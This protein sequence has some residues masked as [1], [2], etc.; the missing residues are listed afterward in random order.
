MPSKQ[1]LKE[2]KWLIVLLP[3]FVCHGLILSAET[4]PA[5]QK[6]Y[7]KGVPHTTKNGKHLSAYDAKRSFFMIGSWGVPESRV[8]KG[9][10]YR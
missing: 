9:V 4:N 5:I 10:D 3:L 7:L 2:F 1:H 6:I 8:Y